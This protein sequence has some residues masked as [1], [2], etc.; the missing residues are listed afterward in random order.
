[1]KS[2]RCC[3]L[4]LVAVIVVAQSA[5]ISGGA[6]K[7]ADKLVQAKDYQGAIQVYQ[8]VVD[9]KPGTADARQAQLAIGELYIRTM[10]KPDDGVKAYQEV[11]SSAPESD[12]A[13][14]AHYELGMHYF[15]AK[16][17]QSAQEQF[18]AIVNK[19]SKLELSNK[20]QLMLAKSYEEAKN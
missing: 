20:A 18:D 14:E 8:T 17:Y 3:T 5:C 12:E 1:M 9:T 2:V 19:F 16:E 15:R 11:I 10:N 7:K 6:S 4:I 13:A